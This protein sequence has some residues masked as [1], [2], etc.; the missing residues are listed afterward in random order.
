LIT[1]AYRD[2]LKGMADYPGES[3]SQV[4]RGEL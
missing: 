3:D 4:H 1:E 2:I